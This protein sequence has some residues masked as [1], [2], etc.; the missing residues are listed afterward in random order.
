MGR[1]RP[2]KTDPDAALEIAMRIFWEKGFEGT[3]MSDLS[4]ATGMAKPGLYATFGDKENLYAKALTRYFDMSTP[5]RNDLVTSSD[6]LEI[7]LRRFLTTIANASADISRPAGCFVVNSVVECA[8]KPP[9]LED[10]GRTCEDKRREAF[11]QRFKAE[12]ERGMLP[13]DADEKA[14][15]DFFDGQ[16]VAL[17]VMGR[18][19]GKPESLHRLIDV[20]M[21]VLPK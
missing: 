10:L 14:L 1:G 7:T 4:E 6:S 8:G 2:R 11:A 19:G 15:A 12:K 21:T 16:C 17:A 13:P 5:T 20:A 9:A 18:A 3:S